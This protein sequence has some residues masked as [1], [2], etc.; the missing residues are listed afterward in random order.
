MSTEAVGTHDAES[1]IHRGP[2][3]TIPEETLAEMFDAAAAEY[4]DYPAVTYRNE[5]G[6]FEEQTFEEFY[7]EA[8]AV[9]GGF[10]DMGLEPGDRLA[11]RMETRYEWT[12]VD[13]ASILAGVVLAPVYMTFTDSQSAYIVEDAGADVLITDDT[14]VPTEIEEVTDE[15]LYI[16]DLP[17]GEFEGELAGGRDPQDLATLIYTSGTT[18]EPKGVKLTHSNVRAE[19]ELFGEAA[20]EIE[21]GATGTCFLPLAHVLQR[22]LTHYYWLNGYTTM[23]STPD[24]LLEDLQEIQPEFIGSVPRVYSKMYEG[25]NAQVETMGTPKAQLVNWGV[26]VA[27]QYGHAQEDG[28]PSMGKGLQL[29]QSIADK[30][31]YGKLRE[32]LGLSN[33]EVAFTGGASL[34][35]PVIRFFWG[36][37]VPVLEAYG[38]TETVGGATFNRMDGFRTGTVGKPVAETEIKLARDGEVLL[39]GPTITEGYWDK[40][41]ETEASFTDDW[42]HTGDIGEWDGDYLKIVGRKKNMQVLETGKNIYG[43]PIEEILRQQP[44]IQEAIVVAED[45]KY[46][47][48]LLQPN[49]DKLL[50]FADDHG[51][52]YDSDAVET[53][54]DE[55]TAVPVDFLQ[56]PTVQDLFDDE[57][58]AANE[59]L[60][61]YQTVKKFTILERAL[62]TTHDE[63]TPTFKKR[64]RNILENWDDRI[65]AMYED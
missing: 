60:A 15:V 48:A 56:E 54:G 4:S 39:R 29:K 63:L 40:P 21:P 31:V 6:D 32:E 36:M 16:E 24:D 41:E 22:G 42:Y 34:D 45:R 46:V 20:P 5:A 3:V 59:E 44:H 2:P 61:D 30:L 33:V 14:D 58:T 26:K 50:A 65:E 8:K 47:S 43:D 49:F 35:A 28:G 17:R 12:L 11:L 37:N 64:R 38:A 53:E 52:E 1:D 18:G 19:L 27:K 23:Y 51:I 7:E 62:S 25:V 10:Q 57:V 55:T 13:V 9:A